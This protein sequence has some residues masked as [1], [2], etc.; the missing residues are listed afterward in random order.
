VVVTGAQ[1]G[2]SH[3]FICETADKPAV[4]IFA[5]SQTDALGKLAAG[6][7]KA[8]AKNKDANLRSWITFL[9]PDQSSVD[10]QILQW[11]R[12]HAISNVPTAVF[13]DVGGPPS[14][15]LGKDVEVTVF[16]SVKQK[17]VVNYEF[18]A[19]LLT[20][21][22]VEEVLKAVADLVKK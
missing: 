14:Y 3:C 16:L 19:G 1:R 2:T 4:I 15:R 10:A 20:D 17:V 9:H 12:V 21:A 6:I 13:E 18:R 5:R 11:A 8:I 22:R 7:D